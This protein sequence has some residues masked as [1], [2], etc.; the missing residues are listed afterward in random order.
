MSLNAKKY[1]FV[2][3]IVLFL[4]GCTKEENSIN[5]ND[6]LN[7]IGLFE[8]PMSCTASFIEIPNMHPDSPAIVRVIFI[9]TMQFI[10]IHR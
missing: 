2:F 5:Y 4:N 10:P 8:G 7:G 6:K 3:I 9:W 1:S